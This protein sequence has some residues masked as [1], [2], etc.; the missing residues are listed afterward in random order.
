[1]REGAYNWGNITETWAG[2]GNLY[3]QPEISTNFD[4]ALEWYFADFGSLTT[5]VFDKKVEGYFRKGTE[6]EMV[7]NP[8]NNITQPVQSTKTIN[9]GNAKIQGVELAGQTGLGF[10]CQSLEHFGVQASYTY[11]DDDTE[12][13]R[14]P[15]DP[16]DSL[17][18]TFRNFS[19]L[20]LEGLSQDNYNLVVFYD[21]SVFQTR[22]A[23]S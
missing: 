18:D 2:A 20:P 21:N 4:I 16:T 12:D 9:G 14:T 7:T 13:S 23:Y 1:M 5:T 6:I 8:N 17:E 19:G 22:F 10:M 15:F 11:I 3:L